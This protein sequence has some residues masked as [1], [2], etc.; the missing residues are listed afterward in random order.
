MSIHMHITEGRAV[1]AQKKKNDRLVTSSLDT[2]SLLDAVL[3]LLAALLALL[4]ALLALLTLYI[5]LLTML[6]TEGR[7]VGEGTDE[8]LPILY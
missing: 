1:G 2:C 7:A 5:A 3:A 4:A 8:W 6:T